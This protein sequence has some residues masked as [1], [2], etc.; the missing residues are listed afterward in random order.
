MEKQQSL[1]GFDLKHLVVMALGNIIGSGIFLA[2]GTVISLA[3]PGALL[4]YLLG[5]FIMLLEVMFIAEMSIVNPAPGS[6]RVHAAEVFGPGVGFVNGW[7]F[8]CSGLLGMASEVTAAAIYTSFWFP[9]VPLWIFCLIFA[10]IM[11]IFNFTDVRG[12]SRIET[13][14]AS[15]KVISL[16]LF[17]LFGIL[18]VLRLL[19]FEINVSSHGFTSLNDFLPHGFNGLF[20]AMLIVLFSFTGTGIIGLAV[21]DTNRP[22]RDLPPAIY[23]ITG[24]VTALYVLAILFLMLLVPWQ[25][26]STAQSPFVTVLQSYGIPY[27]G[28]ILNFI[29]LSASLSGLNSSMYSASR[30]L[31]SLGKGKQAPALFMKT[32]EQG[33]PIYAVGVSSLVL[34]L[35]AVLSYVLPRQAFIILL[36]ASGFLAMFNWLTISVTHYFYRQKVLRE[37]PEK[38]KYKVPGYPYGTFLAIVLIAA[39]L[40]TSPLYAGQVPS[41]IGGIGIIGVI[42]LIYF[43]LELHKRLKVKT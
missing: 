18:A 17:I 24:T 13:W 43:G 26:I 35:T 32:N 23:I 3:G 10:L 36:G 30:M 25:Q 1:Q 19:P 20:A 12:L 14:L 15:V 6:F 40:A 29:V 31:Y 41:L 21:A 16:V 8:W 5:G 2:S 28:M 4:A 34:S 9:T 7:M 39:V 11:T 33:V 42:I 38:L 27:A 37:C 22:E